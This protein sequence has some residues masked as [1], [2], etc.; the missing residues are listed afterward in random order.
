MRLHVPHTSISGHWLLPWQRTDG[1]YLH[2][3]STDHVPGQV[4]QPCDHHKL[5]IATSGAYSSACK[6]SRPGQ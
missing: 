6:L 4:L 3:Y 5:G 2:T 1:P